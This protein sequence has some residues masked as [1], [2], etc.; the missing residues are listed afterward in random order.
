LQRRG[1][2]LGLQAAGHLCRRS[3]LVWKV[4]GQRL[5]GWTNADHPTESVPGDASTLPPGANL[6]DADI[7]FTGTIMPPPGSPGLT[8]DEK[9]T[10][11]RW[12]DLGCPINSGQGTSGE[13][14]GWFLDDVR[15]T[16]AVSLPRP[17]VSASPLNQILAGIADA[18][19]GVKPGSLSIKA[20]FPV[21]GRPAGSELADL[22]QPSG[23]GILS[24]P[25]SPPIVDL[26]AGKLAVSVADKQGNVTRVNQSFSVSKLFSVD[27]PWKL[28]VPKLWNEQ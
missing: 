8:D 25:L 24:I 13:K 20:D 9:M 10:I 3:L 23:D 16:L 14:L 1:R 5:D 12:V 15:P 21:N 2:P 11:A 18:Y 7:D 6:N 17:R 4:F 19:S 26:P 28:F 22:A 27:L